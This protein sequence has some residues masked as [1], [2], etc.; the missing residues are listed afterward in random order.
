M[1]PEKLQLFDIAWIDGDDKSKGIHIKVQKDG[2]AQNIT[3]KEYL[4]PE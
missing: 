3:D 1:I 2:D 4:T